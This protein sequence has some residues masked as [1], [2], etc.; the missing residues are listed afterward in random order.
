MSDVSEVHI[1]VSF[2]SGQLS[3]GLF[4]YLGSYKNNPPF[5]KSLCALFLQYD[6]IEIEVRL[7]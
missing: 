5:N 7:W 2:D 1:D 4:S 3:S 6:I